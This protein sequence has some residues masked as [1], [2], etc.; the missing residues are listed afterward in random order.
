MS[1]VCDVCENSMFCVKIKKNWKN[2]KI[3]WVSF[4]THCAHGE[5]SS[6]SLELMTSPHEL[7]KMCIC[8][9]MPSS[10]ARLFSLFIN[11]LTN[12]KGI[13]QTYD[14]FPTNTCSRTIDRLF[15]ENVASRCR[16]HIDSSEPVD[17][18]FS[19]K[20]KVFLSLGPEEGKVCIV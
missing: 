5:R 4:S 9:N 2:V 15:I 17:G 18:R 1:R 8:E 19:H 14:E 3:P 16:W 12:L 6:S 20:F 11:L 10:L 13:F 7:W